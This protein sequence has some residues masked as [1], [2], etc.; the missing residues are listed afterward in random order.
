MSS[1][2]TPTNISENYNRSNHSSVK[3]SPRQSSHEN[4]NDN[5]FGSEQ[6]SP[7]SEHTG[8]DNEV[9]RKR[10]KRRI[11][12]SPSQDSSRNRSSSS[13]R[14]I[15]PTVK[16]KDTNSRLFSGNRLIKESPWEITEADTLKGN[17]DNEDID[18]LFGGAVSDDDEPF[19]Q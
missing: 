16:S 18:D 2:S 6:N 19:E 14:S 3:S 1:S 9:R 8:S 15:T 10:V 4:E 5:L 7:P 11:V 13:S 12:E 17:S